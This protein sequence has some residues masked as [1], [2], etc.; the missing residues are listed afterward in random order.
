MDLIGWLIFVA[1]LGELVGLA[2]IAHLWLRRATRARKLVWTFGL[3]I[4][5]AG[6]LAYGALFDLNRPGAPSTPSTE[7]SAA[8][9]QKRRGA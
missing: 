5:I 9:G 2:C 7:I 3:L 6:A 1:I 4:P 8:G